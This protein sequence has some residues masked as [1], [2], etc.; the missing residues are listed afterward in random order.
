MRAL[1]K[2]IMLVV[3]VTFV[4][5]LVFDYGMNVS[6][7]S[8][9]G[10]GDVVLKVN[11][12]SI[13][14][15]TFSA[16]YQALADQQRASGGPPLT[17][18]EDQRNLEDAVTEQ[19]VQQAVLQQEYQRHGISVTDDEVRQAMLNVPPQELRDVPQ[20]QT[21]S[22]F[23]I[24]KYQRYLRSGID[25]AFT[26]ALERQYRQEIPRLKLFERLTEDVYV[27]D[28]DVWRAY[29][30]QHETVR[31][32]LLVLLPQVVA[33]GADITVTDDEAR[34][35][36][37]AHQSDFA[38]PAAA[39]LSYV[40]VSRRPDAADT[41]AALAR[42]RRVRQEIVGGADF[43]TVA[44][45]ESADSVSA[46]QG[47]DLGEATKGQFVPEFEQ[48]A[49]ALRPGQVSQPA[50]SG[51][52]YHIIKLESQ[53]GDTYH[54]RHILIP[55]EPI[56]DH[57]TAI[58]S[59]TDT[60]DLL[61]AEQ[62]DPAMLDTVATHLGLTVAQAPPLLQGDRMQ[63]RGDVVPD[64][65]IWAFEAEPGKT[66]P[67]IEA[68]PAYYVFRLD[69]LHAKGVPPLAAIREQVAS[70]VRLEKQWQATRAIARKVVDALKGG[71]SFQQASQ[72]Q[73][74]E[75]RDLPPF[76]RAQPSPILGDAPDVIGLAFGLPVGT[77]GGPVENDMAMFFVQ[78]L[79]RQPADSAA[80][81][82]QK[83]Q[84]RQQL[85]QQARQTRLRVILSSLRQKA[86]VVDHRAELFRAQ[87]EE[88]GVLGGN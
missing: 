6:G 66:S 33:S 22:Q 3:A 14:R 20:F 35:Y 13:D 50:A 56:G 71:A 81:E 10:P 39:F 9:G 59:R 65:Q 16:A 62:T 79:E 21:D 82:Q 26:E 68:Q 31:A 23:D 40:A 32:R 77:V 48:A 47:G 7:R 46:A 36:Y 30:D 5:W 85:T 72:Q 67:V 76:S 2:W 25:P 78:P 84:L 8:V 88:R 54:A 60:L 41:A 52:G 15:K 73:G 1:A 58:D 18:I 61:A 63:L 42:A 17:S 49:L 29:R 24:Q 69:S 86:N 4:G 53:S 28:A 75:T 57:L 34:Q 51:F 12:Q 43:A 37:N 83:E 80:F 87:P 74:L 64:V 27:S 44:K 45:R 70:K 38:Q 55:I 19:L 11:G